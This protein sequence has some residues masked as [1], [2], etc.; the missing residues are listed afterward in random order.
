VAVRARSVRLTV[1]HARRRAWRRA[2]LRLTRRRLLWVDY[3]AS[4]RGRPRWGHGRPPNPHLAALIDSHRDATEASLRTIAD[5][6][7]PM[8]RLAAFDDQDSAEPAWLNN[9][10]PA[11]DAAALYAFVASR[12]L[13]RYVEIGSGVSTR[14]V[15]R[16]RRDHERDFTIT[17]IDP[18][19]RMYVEELCDH[20][21][22]EPLELTDLSRFESL[23]AND[24]VFLDGTHLV[25]P[26]GDSVTFFLDVLPRLPAGVLVG[27]HDVMFPDDYGQGEIDEHWAVQY[28]LGAALVAGASRLRPVL[29]AWAISHTPRTDE[30][31]APLWSQPGLRVAERFGSAFWMEIA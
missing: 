22:R 26:D 21:V 9:Y 7:E 5:Y 18:R 10:L 8:G 19:P 2:V 12:P 15:A 3:P 20:V 1:R 23:E 14:F 4:A 25:F 27:I 31:L 16:A 28:L 29:P 6:A 13:R 24:V 17:S 11:I 30:I